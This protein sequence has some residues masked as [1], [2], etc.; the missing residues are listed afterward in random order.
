MD[1]Y[2]RQAVEELIG[3]TNQDLISPAAIWKMAYT[4]A[5]K[6]NRRQCN[7]WG[8]EI[9]EYNKLAEFLIIAA[10]LAEKANCLTTV[11]EAA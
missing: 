3:S 1:E 7:D 10:G 2:L 11:S 4:L 5:E 6:Y 9:S 8:Q